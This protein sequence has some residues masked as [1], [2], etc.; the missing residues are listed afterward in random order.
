[1]ADQWYYNHQGQQ[2]GPVAANEIK[3]LA[4]SGN[5]KPDD[6]VWKAGTT[7]RR[8]AS[9]FKGLFSQVAS[10]TPPPIPPD[11]EPPPI[12]PD[13][14]PLPIPPPIPP[15]SAPPPLA[16]GF[17]AYFFQHFRAT[18]WPE[19]IGICLGLV[20]IPAASLIKPL[21]GFRGLCFVVAGAAALSLV[22]G[23]WYTFSRLIAYY[24]DGQ[25]SVPRRARSIAAP[26][27]YGGLMFLVPMVPW[28]AGEFF[29][30]P[31]GLLATIFP[32]F[33]KEQARWFGFVDEKPCAPTKPATS[34]APTA[35]TE[36]SVSRPSDKPSKASQGNPSPTTPTATVV[37]KS[38]ASQGNPSPTTPTATA[39]VV[40]KSA[41]GGTGES[42][43]AGEGS[44]F[45]SAWHGARELELNSLLSD[46]F[47]KLEPRPNEN[48]TDIQH[49][50]AEKNRA[51]SV[52][53]EFYRKYAGRKALSVFI[54][55]NVSEVY[56]RSNFKL[57][58][59]PKTERLAD[60]GL[61]YGRGFG[62]SPAC[63]P[64]VGL[65]SELLPSKAAAL[66]VNKGDEVHCWATIDP[67]GTECVFGW[68]RRPALRPPTFGLGGVGSDDPVGG[69]G[70]VDF[71]EPLYTEEVDRVQASSSHPDQG[72]SR[73]YRRWK[74]HQAC[75]VRV[76]TDRTEL[77]DG[78]ERTA[79][80][81]QDMD[82]L[83][84]KSLHQSKIH[85]A[86][87]RFGYSSENRF[88][89]G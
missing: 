22:S 33:R 36:K 20:A 14:D 16:V 4:S 58:V 6:L 21:I 61:R 48:L 18:R 11:D 70:P 53:E 75:A 69:P 59:V 57:D 78:R 9:Q 26:L 42:R 88:Q 24:L 2:F 62:H 19:A 41:A 72:P 27:A 5:L 73:L 13:E 34:P 89:V 15:H 44:S 77:A 74:R 81:F 87:K 3:R 23:I 51:K 65:S 37:D 64:Y 28:V 76:E 55:E 49:A 10:G 71:F 38:G 52:Y 63:H 56:G 31:H 66:K 1:M 67:N 39:T 80:R 12:P 25:R 84:R 35:Q 54:V 30:P 68:R 8:P 46:L 17:F 32:D 7:S 60:G 45:A 47:A 79:G 29:S 43:L 83:D 86:R 50:E 40:D 82:R 85:W